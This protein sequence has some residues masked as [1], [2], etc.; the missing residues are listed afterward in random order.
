MRNVLNWELGAGGAFG[1]HGSESFML[2]S[3]LA[4][5]V[6]ILSRFR[7]MVLVLVRSTGGK[8]VIKYSNK[9]SNFWGGESLLVSSQETFLRP[10]FRKTLF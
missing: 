5:S 8:G 9:A 10:Y 7:L 4:A 1:F 2:L 3:V 6:C